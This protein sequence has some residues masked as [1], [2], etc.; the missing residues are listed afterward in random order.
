MRVS[1]EDKITLVKADVY[2]TTSEI[3]HNATMLWSF[4][5]GTSAV[6]WLKSDEENWDRAVDVL[7]RELQ[8]TDRYKVL[9]GGRAQLKFVANIAIATK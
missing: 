1:L 8:N 4:V 6:G 3:T 2:V 5:G 9:D 7:K